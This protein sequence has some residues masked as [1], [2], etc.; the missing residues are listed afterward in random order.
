M[1][2]LIITEHL[3]FTNGVAKHLLY[4]LKGFN[5]KHDHQIT[6]ICG[7]GDAISSFK[8]LVENI[9]IWS[10]IKHENRSIKNIFKSVM[11]LFY[12]QKVN[13]FN[14]I[15]TH[16]HYAANIAFFISLITKAKVIQTVHGII[17]PIGKLK[18]YP[19]KYF[20]VVNEHI[21][22]YLVKEERKDL[23]QIVLVRNGIQIVNNIKK[24]KNPKLRII[25]AGRFTKIKAFDVYLNAI[26]LLSVETKN[27]VDFY[28]TGKGE[29]FDFLNSLIKSLDIQ[30]NV[31]I[32]QEQLTDL[33]LTTDILINPTRSTYEGFPMTIVEAAFTKNLIISSDF[34]GY[35]SIL[36]N[37]NNCMIFGI[38]DT[39]AL[40]ERITYAVENYDNLNV[41]VENMY[42]LAV[43]EFSIEKMINKTL[44]FYK[45]I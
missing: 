38:N 20:I 28:L 39:Y 24:Q 9:L 34:L 45:R 11:K 25:S 13:N 3:N 32:E 41:L 27:K 42:N 35:D 18:H 14:I 16:N 37:G 19:S 17:E 36:K 40:A 12:F 30:V 2:I 1:K 6:I 15:H 10:F 29:E 33:L 23:G 5:N 26:A 8:P 43:K 31:L 21:I 44:D 7:G 4:F 22:K